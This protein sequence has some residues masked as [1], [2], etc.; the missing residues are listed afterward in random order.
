MLA[1]IFHFY[2]N[3]G[4][5]LCSE[6]GKGFRTALHLRRHARTHDEKT[7]KC[8][9]C[10]LTFKHSKNLKRHREIHLNLKYNCDHCSKVY[11][12]KQCLRKHKCEEII[13]IN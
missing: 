11:A 12:T 5:F 4:D 13:S 9:E 1:L 10:P 7:L 8:S 2:L 3:I 6:C